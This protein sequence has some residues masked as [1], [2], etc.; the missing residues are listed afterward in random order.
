VIA[1]RWLRAIDLWD[2]MRLMRR[3]RLV[4]LGT[5]SALVVGAGGQ[6]LASDTGRSSVPP[7]RHAG[8]SAASLRRADAA[9]ISA[10]LFAAR[11]PQ[12]AYQPLMRT[13]L[14]AIYPAAEL[15]GSVSGFD[16]GCILGE[17]VGFSSGG[18][19]PNAT[20]SSAAATRTVLQELLPAGDLGRKG[21]PDLL[22][23]RLGVLHNTVSA[24]IT[25]RSSRTGARLWSRDLTGAKGVFSIPYPDPDRV[26]AG[27]KPGVL[28]IQESEPLGRI[29]SATVRLHVT[30]VSGAGAHLWSATM[31]GKIAVAGNTTTFT[32]VPIVIGDIHDVARRGHDVLVDVLSGT[33]KRS[34]RSTI[35]DQPEVVSAR[36]G[37][38]A[39]RGVPATSTDGLAE[40]VPVP[41]LNRDGLD[42]LAAIEPGGDGGIVAEQGDSGARIWKSTGVLVGVGAQISPVGQISGSDTGDLAISNDID[43]G[44]RP[45]STVSLVNG[46]TGRLR[47]TVPA[48][49]AFDIG[50]AGPKLQPAVG[51][52]TR[53]RD[54][55]GSQSETLGM[56]LSPR[57]RQGNVVY[58]RTISATLAAKPARSGDAKFSLDPFGDVQ[59]DGSQDVEVAVAIRLGKHVVHKHGVVSGRDGRLIKEPAGLPT[60]GSLQH[61]RGA[62][63]VKTETES[64]GLRLAAYDAATG[65]R[66]YQRHVGRTTGLHAQVEYGVRVTGHSC[67]D[68][69]V[70]AMS[71]TRTMIGLFDAKGDPLWSVT[72]SSSALRGGHLHHGK[73]PAS[74]C[75]S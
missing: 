40:V 22:D 23:Y 21:V 74:Y 17:E 71:R 61:G 75:V 64:G 43:D 12:L 6:A 8:P 72:A 13:E 52:V 66:L 37:S 46:A 65:T 51:L 47:W 49:C 26:G 11:S 63:L 16:S 38:I 29:A 9:A 62:D 20:S 19:S 45:H 15:P 32:N 5:A 34:G 50:K 70:G 68:L 24:G 48:I 54:G 58:T 69:V 60:D 4:V 3:I 18:V 36:D 25:A 57:D 44:P 56:T 2:M 55:G 27:D 41:D 67:S 10:A 7:S 28:L 1:S 73:R 35:A 31:T 33:V 39:A 42:D 53:L 59:P 30:A 14:A